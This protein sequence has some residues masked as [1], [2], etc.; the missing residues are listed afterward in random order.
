MQIRHRYFPVLDET[1]EGQADVIYCS[2]S[3]STLR[4]RVTLIQ[5]S[6]ITFHVFFFFFFLNS[7]LTLYSSA[8]FPQ[9]S[10]WYFKPRLTCIYILHISKYI[11]HCISMSACEYVLASVYTACVVFFF[12]SFLCRIELQ[13]SGFRFFF[14]LSS[15]D[16]RQWS[17]WTAL[18]LCRKNTLFCGREDKQRCRRSIE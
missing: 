18:F 13:S 6:T 15:A 2:L 3:I 10:N 17:V 4:D 7:C 11:C 5:M 9:N 14:R 16:L 8:L 12:F 1:Q